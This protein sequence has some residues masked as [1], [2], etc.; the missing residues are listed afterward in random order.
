MN[1]E[2]LPVVA[3][4]LPPET[5]AEKMLPQSQV[6]DLIGAEKK[7]AYERGLKEGQQA[8]QQVATPPVAD[9]VANQLSPDSIAQKALA[10]MKAQQAT[11]QQDNQ[12]LELQRQTERQQQEL[13]ASMSQKVELAKKELE[14]FDEVFKS[15]GLTDDASGHQVLAAVLSYSDLVDNG[16]HVAYEL[17]KAPEKLANFLTLASTSPGAAQ[18]F[19]TQLSSSIKSNEAAKAAPKLTRPLERISSSTAATSGSFNPATAS[20]SEWRRKL[21]GK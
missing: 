17:A 3:P 6:N 14:D 4:A 15:S 10:L 9:V 1:D 20:V 11:E 13:Q 2:V 12:Q 5:V 7:A 18:K 8:A 19:I 16:G 21:K